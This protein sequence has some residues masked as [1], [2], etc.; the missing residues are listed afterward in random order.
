[1]R[2]V[3]LICPIITTLCLSF[4][5]MKWRETN[6]EV[7]F[8]PVPIILKAFMMLHWQWLV[9]FGMLSGFVI[10]Y[11]AGGLAP[12]Q[13]KTLSLAVIAIGGILVGFVGVASV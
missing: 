13:M 12:H 1:M 6:A 3:L 5:G 4:L 7:Q 10:W 9:P 11:A 8:D 2:L